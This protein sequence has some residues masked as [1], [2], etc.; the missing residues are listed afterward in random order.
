M[1]DDRYTDIEQKGDDDGVDIIVRLRHKKKPPL[2]LKNSK[3]NF[4]FDFID[5]T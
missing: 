2:F 4:N 3:Q 5:I 1:Y